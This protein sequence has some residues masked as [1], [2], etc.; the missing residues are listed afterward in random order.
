MTLEF[1]RSGHF[2]GKKLDHDSHVSTGLQ[3]HLKLKYMKKSHSTY[4]FKLMVE[5]AHENRKE[6]QFN[7][8]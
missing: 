7:E 3:H 1:K 6:K 4:L 2:L 5:A 8:K